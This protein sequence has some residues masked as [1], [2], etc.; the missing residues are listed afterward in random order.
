LKPISLTLRRPDDWHVHLRDGALLAAVLPATAAHFARAIVMPNLKPPVLCSADALAYRARIRTL[1]PAGSSFE[2][3]MTCYLTDDTDADDLAAGHR[4]G[5]FTAAKL[6]PA[7]ATTN[8]HSGVTDLRRLAQVLERMQAIG[9][10]LLIHGEVVDPA[11]DVFDREA[12]FVTRELAPL[13]ARY[14]A[15]RIV[16]EHVTTAE[17]VAFVSTD[18]GPTAATVTPHHLLLDRN[19]MFAGGLRPHHYC[20]PVIKRER[21]RLA[22]RAAV[23]SGSPRFFLGTD[24]APHLRQAKEHDCGCAGIFNAATALAC[25]AEVFAEENRLDALEGFAAIHGPAFYGLPANT[26]QIVLETV[27]AGSPL[28]DLDTADGPVRQFA[29]AA[30]LRWRVRPAEGPA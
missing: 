26:S 28:A 8:S 17:G 6:Y 23:T 25:Y 18:P 16:L 24:S 7:G 3:L 14:P 2:P 27:A 12:V 30:A 4:D 9:M 20:L 1:L 15:L 19:A 21:H 11:V 29:P 22:L 5:V 10:P 13:R